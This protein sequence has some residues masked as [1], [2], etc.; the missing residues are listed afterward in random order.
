MPRPDT[1][2]L[3]AHRQ[4]HERVRMYLTA[5]VQR[6]DPPLALLSW[7]QAPHRH[8]KPTDQSS[9]QVR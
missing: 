5:S 8:Q 4:M 6:S 1:D 2:I 7:L 9:S 3:H